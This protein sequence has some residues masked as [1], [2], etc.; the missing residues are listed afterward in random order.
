MRA[1]DHWRAFCSAA[2]AALDRAGQPAWPLLAAGA[3]ILGLASWHPVLAAGWLGL[4]LTALAGTAPRLYRKMR[5]PTGSDR[6][7]MRC[8]S[9]RASGT[10][11]TGARGR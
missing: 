9:W 8:T 11:P 10:R 7:I 5:A 1:R 3:C 6:V 4:A 2:L